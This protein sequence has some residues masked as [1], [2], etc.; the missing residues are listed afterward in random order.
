M[1]EGKSKMGKVT[2]ASKGK[3]NKERKK[4]VGRAQQAHQLPPSPLI[5]SSRLTVPPLPGK[6]PGGALPPSALFLPPEPEAPTV[7][8]FV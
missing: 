2:G 1:R 6:P 7:G 8:D 3:E 5:S 4:E